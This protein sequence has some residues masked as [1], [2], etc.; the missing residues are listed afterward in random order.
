MGAFFKT[1][2]LYFFAK[3]KGEKRWITPCVIVHSLRSRKSCTWSTEVFI[4]SNVGADWSLNPDEKEGY[5]RE[6]DWMGDKWRT[7]EKQLANPL[8]FWFL[9]SELPNSGLRT[10]LEVGGFYNFNFE[11]SGL[12]G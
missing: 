2:F 1:D 3:K 5:R 6:E 8:N 10:L 4:A 12:T 11:L 7:I 9:N